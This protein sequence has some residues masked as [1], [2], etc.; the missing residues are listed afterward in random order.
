MGAYRPLCSQGGYAVAERTYKSIL[1]EV[2]PD[3][4]QA[5]RSVA[6]RLDARGLFYAARRLYLAHDERPREREERLLAEKKSLHILDY[7]YFNNNIIPE[8]EA[9]H[10][11]IDGLTREPRGHLH[12]VHTYKDEGQEIGTEFLSTYWVPPYYFDKVIF[13]EKHGVALGL[14]DEGLGEKYDAAIVA[15]RGYGTEADRRLLQRFADEG[16]QLF[17]V[18]DC[19]I[20]GYGILSNLRNGNERVGGVDGEVIDLGLSLEHASWY[21]LIGE[22]ATRQKAIPFETVAQLTEDELRL[23]TGTQRTRKSW[24]YT[25]F[26]LNELPSEERLPFV[27]RQLTANGVRPKVIPPDDYLGDTAR[28]YARSDLEDRARDAILDAVGADQIIDALLD[29]YEDRYTYG[30]PDALRRHIAEVFQSQPR[31]S[32]RNVLLDRIAQLGLPLRYD[33]RD[34]VVPH[35]RDNLDE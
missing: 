25:R 24:Q 28:Q 29:E 8:F 21:G 3:A 6:G 32:W 20:D 4:I 16:Y 35:I 13:I 22:E 27:E 1:L 18:H 2:L 10:G 14:V 17:I 7:S 30:D 19:D 12:E 9:E 26:E 5:E 33:L 23:F 31:R 15:S 34:D 11:E